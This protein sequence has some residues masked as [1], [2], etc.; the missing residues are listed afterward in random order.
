MFEEIREIEWYR[1]M[2]YRQADKIAD[3]EDKIAT[4]V[5]VL[6]KLESTKPSWRTSI[7][8]AI[9]GLDG[10][11]PDWRSFGENK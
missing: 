1:G 7:D 11:F 2:V 10:V 9:G 5:K 6:V 4:L 3:L 8:S